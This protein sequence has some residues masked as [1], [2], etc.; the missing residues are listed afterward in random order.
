MI[1]YPHFGGVRVW[2]DNI[3]TGGPGS[4]GAAAPPLQF[5]YSDDGSTWTQA[6]DSRDAATT[7]AIGSAG[8]TDWSWGDVGGHRYWQMRLPVS[9]STA[10]NVMEVQYLV[11]DSGSTQLVDHYEIWDMQLTTPAKVRSIPFSSTPSASTPMDFSQF[12]HE[13]VS[14]GVEYTIFCV[15]PDGSVSSPFQALSFSPPQAQAFRASAVGPP[16]GA[17]YILPSVDGSSG[18][19]LKTDGAGNLSWVSA[20]AAGA[21]SMQKCTGSGTSWTIPSAFTTLV[22]VFIDGLLGD[23]INDW[24][25]SG[26]TI[27]TAFAALHNVFALTQA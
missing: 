3:T 4:L 16:T 7:G 27:T 15:A 25:V 17:I 11:A 22:A 8:F 26:S 14:E 10:T 23:P 21:V 19:L 18:D 9:Q 20:G 6:D 5:W 12:T 24:T 1:S 13:V 2:Q